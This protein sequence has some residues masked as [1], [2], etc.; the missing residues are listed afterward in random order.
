MDFLG[1]MI[2]GG[3]IVAI[4]AMVAPRN[5]FFIGIIMLLLV[6]ILGILSLFGELSTNEIHP[7]MAL[8]HVISFVGSGVY[9]LNF[10]HKTEKGEE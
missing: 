5:Q 6:T 8:L 1:N 3:G 10:I 9:A 7:V 2:M 4:G